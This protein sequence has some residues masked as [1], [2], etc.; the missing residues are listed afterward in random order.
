V[1]TPS[2]ILSCIW[3]V[4]GICLAGNPNRYDIW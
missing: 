2:I 1:D 4:P 3:F